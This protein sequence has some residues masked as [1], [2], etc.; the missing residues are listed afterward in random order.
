[1]TLGLIGVMKTVRH[2]ST[3]NKI[4]LKKLYSKIVQSVVD[5]ST[6]GHRTSSDRP[7]KRENEVQMS[8]RGSPFSLAEMSCVFGRK[9]GTSRAM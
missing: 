4:Y 1:M 7:I 6:G 8:R 5:W 2:R 9:F 3:G